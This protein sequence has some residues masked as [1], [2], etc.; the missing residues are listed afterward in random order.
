[1]TKSVPALLSGKR[2]LIMG[3]AN[4]HSIA[5]GIARRLSEQGAELAFT[6]QTPALG[7]RV[8]PLA[9]SLGSEFVLPC[10]VGMKPD[11]GD[12]NSLD[13]MFT[14][15]AKRLSDSSRAASARRTDV[16]SSSRSTWYATR[17]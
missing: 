16:T 4:D 10:D 3:V 9:K 1:M 7:K 12:P 17:R 5:W 13:S 11:A 2:G 8:I 6:Y 15:V 14:R